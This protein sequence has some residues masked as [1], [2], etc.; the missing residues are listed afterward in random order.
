MP[1]ALLTPQHNS[2][3]ASTG[4]LCQHFKLACSNQCPSTLPASLTRTITAAGTDSPGATNIRPPLIHPWL[5]IR[6]AC[7]VLSAPT[8]HCSMPRHSN[9][10]QLL[11]VTSVRQRCHTNV[12]SMLLHF[13]FPLRRADEFDKLFWAFQK[14]EEAATVNSTQKAVLSISHGIQHGKGPRQKSN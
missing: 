9:L 10:Q 13:L 6:P 8:I 1:I 14:E 3:S 12:K 7:P 11:Q 2:A 5:L 4:A